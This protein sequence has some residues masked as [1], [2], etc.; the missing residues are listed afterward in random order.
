MLLKKHSLH[1]IKFE[2]AQ[3]ALAIA[4]DNCFCLKAA[5]AVLFYAG[6]S[7]FDRFGQSSVSK[8][9]NAAKSAVENAT[10][11]TKTGRIVRQNV[12]SATIDYFW[13][14]PVLLAT[15]SSRVRSSDQRVTLESLAQTVTTE[16][17]YLSTM[18]IV[19]N[20]PR[21]K[22]IVEYMKTRIFN[23]QFANAVRNVVN[24]TASSK[25]KNLGKMVVNELLGGFTNFVD[26]HCS[27]GS[28]DHAT[29]NP[30]AFLLRSGDG[31][32]PL[33]WYRNANSGEFFNILNRKGLNSNIVS[34]REKF[35]ILDTVGIESR[36]RDC[37]INFINVCTKINSASRLL[38]TH[39][40]KNSAIY[41]IFSHYRDVIQEKTKRGFGNVKIIGCKVVISDDKSMDADCSEATA[42]DKINGRMFICEL[43]EEAFLKGIRKEEIYDKLYLKILDITNTK[44]IKNGVRLF[45]T[46][47]Y[48]PKTGNLNNSDKLQILVDGYVALFEFLEFLESSSNTKGISISEVPV[49][50]FRVSDLLK[51]FRNFDEY[52]EYHQNVLAL[53]REV[54]FDPERS[55]TSRDGILCNDTVFSIMAEQSLLKSDPVLNKLLNSNMSVFIKAVNRYNNE[56]KDESIARDL[57]MLSIQHVPL[58]YSIEELSSRPLEALEKELIAQE[59]Y[60]IGNFRNGKDITKQSF[61]DICDFATVLFCTMTAEGRPVLD[62]DDFYVLRGKTLLDDMYMP[63]EFITKYGKEFVNAALLRRAMAIQVSYCVLLGLK[64]PVAVQDINMTWEDFRVFWCICGVLS[65]Y[66]KRFDKIIKRFGATSA[67]ATYLMYAQAAHYDSYFKTN[68]QQTDVSSL[69]L[70]Y[71]NNSLAKCSLPPELIS[72]DIVN[73]K[74]IAVLRAYNRL[75]ATQK[76]LCRVSKDLLDGVVDVFGK[77]EEGNAFD[78]EIEN[79]LMEASYNIQTLALTD[80]STRKFSQI[81]LARYDIDY[82]GYVCINSV[83]YLYKERYYVHSAG[84]FVEMF[85]SDFSK[86][87]IDKITADVL[88]ELNIFVRLRGIM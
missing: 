40:D 68:C 10:I 78:S 39:K 85:H 64:L 51:R 15:I 71:E 76:T 7:Y 70:Y 35:S 81:L 9:R 58:G 31:S 87:S 42:L 16:M 43:M 77:F 24:L 54:A 86:Y 61:I 69:Y 36:K 84:F 41:D 46:E 55:R 14:N 27:N 73:H 17:L 21:N 37:S 79:T 11:K 53:Y 48:N 8:E 5:S 56:N 3:F 22:Y 57:A 50:I 62:G 80:S 44:S 38:F 13:N 23:Q 88:E 1:N 75:M 60:I 34:G 47:T 82:L 66:M 59:N 52:I 65:A 32:G 72:Q 19:F 6:Y 30:D 12:V 26:K 18:K 25:Q 20:V 28:Y 83:R 33:M 4:L 2:D 67:D 45:A 63:D 29:A 74:R 49:E